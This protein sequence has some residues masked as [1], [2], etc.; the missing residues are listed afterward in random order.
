MLDINHFVLFLDR[1]GVVHAEKNLP[2]WLNERKKPKHLEVKTT[3]KAT[4]ETNRKRKSS[5]ILC[6]TSMFH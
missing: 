4:E 1:N 3:V 6:K 5:M 2:F